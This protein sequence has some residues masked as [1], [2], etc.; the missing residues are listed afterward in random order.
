M[1]TSSMA[2]KR[3]SRRVHEDV[4]ITLVAAGGS[5]SCTALASFALDRAVYTAWNDAETCSGCI[6]SRCQSCP[7]VVI[8]N[9]RHQDIAAAAVKH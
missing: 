1:R 7:V 9:R 3:L 6:V 4:K 8:S 2:P 5:N